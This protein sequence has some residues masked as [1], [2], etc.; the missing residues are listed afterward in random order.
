MQELGQP[1]SEIVGELGAGSL[2][3]L[4]PTAFNDPSQCV[5]M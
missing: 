5:L 2:P 4:D 3:T 1:P